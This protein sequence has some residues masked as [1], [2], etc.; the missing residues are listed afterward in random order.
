MKEACKILNKLLCK[1]KNKF[2]FP[3]YFIIRKYL[4]IWTQQ[5]G[6][7]DVFANIGISI[8]D[9]VGDPLIDYLW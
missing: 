8:N 2:S 7:I 6:L 3:G 9:T 4:I 1:Y 5:M